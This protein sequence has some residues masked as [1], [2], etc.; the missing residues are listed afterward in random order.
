MFLKIESFIN[1]N[2]SV[3]EILYEIKLKIKDL[4]N[5]AV[6]EKSYKKVEK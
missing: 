4:K 3:T 5:S 6:I 1:E 2:A